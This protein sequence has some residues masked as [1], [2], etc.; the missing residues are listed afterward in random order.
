MGGGELCLNTTKKIEARL[1]N[2]KHI[3]DKMS[4]SK[5][6]L[7]WLKLLKVSNLSTH[8]NHLAI[9]DSYTVIHTLCITVEID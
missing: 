8:K 6:I 9:V 5:S 3:A 1:A 4:M 7:S 2:K